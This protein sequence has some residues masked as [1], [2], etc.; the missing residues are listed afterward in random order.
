MTQSLL[1]EGK[2]E[3]QE[4]NNLLIQVHKSK[5][6]DYISK[7][8]ICSD[9]FLGEEIESDTQSKFKDFLLLSTGYLDELDEEQLLLEI[10]LTNDEKENLKK[11]NSNVYLLDRPLPIT[12]VK[13]IYASNK[14]I[15]SE[16]M[17]KSLKNYNMGYISEKLFE[18]FPKGKKKFIQYFIEN[19]NQYEVQEYSEKVLKYDKVMGL[20]ASI[21]NTNLY[22]INENNFYQNYSDN[23]FSL[24]YDY[25][26]K[27]IEVKK[28]I[29][30][31]FFTSDIEK[32]FIEKLHSTNYIDK[33]FLTEVIEIIKKDEIKNKLL[34]LRDDPL[35]KKRIL[36]S[37]KN[38]KEP[39]YY[40]ISLLFIYGKKG[41]NSKYAFKDNIIEEIPYEKAENALALFGLYYGYSSLPAYEEIDIKDKEFQ[42]IMNGNEFNIKFKLD[43]K[44]DYSLVES[45][46]QY[47]FNSK[48]EEIQIDYL[49]EIFKKK[50]KA[51]SVN[52]QINQD[53][54]R[55]YKIENK[56]KILDIENIKIKKLNWE[57][58]IDNKMNKYPDI[59]SFPKYYL[60]NFIG[61]FYKKLLSNRKD[62][63]S[64]VETYANKEEFIQKIKKE[65]NKNI[66]N[67][68]FKVF[69]IDKK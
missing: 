24:F 10:I 35:G 46:Y 17:Q 45:L 2:I 9:K 21:K 11:V 27:T 36:D 63:G 23:Y 25:N 26:N 40:Y 3:N 16:D 53:F 7:G 42:K 68:L 39:V 44:L 41:S 4:V 1:L 64:F 65:E 61:Q 59:I 34:M 56:N 43:S 8:L 22:Y 48:K 13:T 33:E 58:F 32:K 52:I 62:D 28:W 57:E 6:R 14:K 55:W 30:D 69:E 49:D 60:V 12:R 15:A 66:Q 67:E 37:F 20:F 50:I 29:K 51:K 54:K 31:N 38:Y 5:F 19:S 47:V 18:S